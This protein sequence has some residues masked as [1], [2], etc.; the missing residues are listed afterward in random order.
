VRAFT[1]TGER[2][3]FDTGVD[4]ATGDFKD[5]E[6]LRRAM[7]GVT[8]MYLL[9]AATDLEQHDANAIEAAKDA[10]LELVV[11][12]RSPGRLRKGLTFRGGTA[13]GRSVSKPPVSRASSSD[14]PR[15][16]ATRSDG[17]RR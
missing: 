3:R 8:R 12:H 1:R 17:S 7:D 5:T 11:K 15:S 16:R 4:V 6:S 14:R 9:S 2:A 10:G 13:P